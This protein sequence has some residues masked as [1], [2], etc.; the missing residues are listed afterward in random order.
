MTRKQTE[1][2]K[3]AR[4]AVRQARGTDANNLLENP[5]FKE[6]WGTLDTEV[7]NTWRLSPNKERREDAWYMQRNLSNLKAVFENYVAVGES[8]RK[9]LLN[10][11]AEDKVT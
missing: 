6:V 9:E 11:D 3:K 1:G 10:F 8:A 7:I 5:V 4:L 2:E